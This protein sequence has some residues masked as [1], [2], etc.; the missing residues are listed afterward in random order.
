M[1]TAL[2]CL[3]LSGC[4]SSFDGVCGAVPLGNTDGG[5]AVVRVHCEP[6]K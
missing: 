3:L 2:L 1:R 6:V 5:V 4:A